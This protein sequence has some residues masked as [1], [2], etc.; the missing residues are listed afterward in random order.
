[1]VREYLV[2][3]KGV[4]KLSSLL[5][6]FSEW[7]RNAGQRISISPETQAN[8][9]AYLQFKSKN[10]YNSNILYQKTCEVHGF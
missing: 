5:S 3:N 9:T 6:N 7:V 8:F 10:T 4:Y 1:M 2:Q